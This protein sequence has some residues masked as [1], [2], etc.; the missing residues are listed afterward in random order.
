MEDG[1]RSWGSRALLLSWSMQA[2]PPSSEHEA[3]GSA[4]LEPMLGPS[5]CQKGKSDRTRRVE[6][7]NGRKERL[8]R[9]TDRSTRSPSGVTALRLAGREERVDVTERIQSSERA[10]ILPELSMALLTM[11]EMDRK[12]RVVPAS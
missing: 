6:Q 5:H 11:P 10:S 8:P 3:N 1:R 9:P 7:N 12:E 4:T 2:V